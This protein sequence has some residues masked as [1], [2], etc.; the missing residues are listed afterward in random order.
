M[1]RFECPRCG[2]GVRPTDQQ[3][4]RCGEILREKPRIDS[5]GESPKITVENML[6]Q[7]EIPVRLGDSDYVSVTRMRSMLER[8]EQ[9]LARREN[10]MKW[11]EDELLSSLEEIESDTRTMERT[12][13]RLE[14]EEA[15]LS[16]KERALRQREKELE[17]YSDRLAEWQRVMERYKEFMQGEDLSPADIEKIIQIQKDFQEALVKER[18]RLKLELKEELS[19]DLEAITL[20]EEQFR[21]TESALIKKALELRNMLRDRKQADEQR[22]SSEGEGPTLDELMKET[23][24]ELNSQIGAG[25]QVSVNNGVIPTFIEPLDRALQGGIPKKHVI[26]V[27]G[28]AGTMKSTLSYYILHHCAAERGIR[29]MYFSLE[30]KRESIIRQME[31]LGLPRSESRENLIL[32]D[33]VDLRKT[34]ANEDC[35]WREILK[36]YVQNVKVAKDFDCF[37]LDSLESFKAMSGFVFSR[38]DLAELFDW[39]REMG[40]TTLLISEL[41]QE[42]LLDSR[43]GELYLADGSIELTMKEIGKSIQRW[44]RVPKMRG[45]N[46]DQRYYSFKFENG[47]F[48]LT[49]PLTTVNR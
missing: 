8:R 28:A 29:S 46:I 7:T 11:R 23:F 4:G 45:A 15:L 22:I 2:S 17:S 20:K 49:H 31:R 39:F 24:E 26:M 38:E 47:S 32:V 1:S 30:Q 34:M 10:E 44:I 16:E 40:L 14:Q 12:M 6:S 3:C 42:E 43:Q 19:D 35:D 33:M 21:V 25:L 37:V 48:L 36:R 13:E 5:N 27:N 41:P 9:D 18:D